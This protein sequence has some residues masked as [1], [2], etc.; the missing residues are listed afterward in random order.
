MSGCPLEARERE[1]EVKGR[2]TL[3]CAMTMSRNAARFSFGI[4]GRMPTHDLPGSIDSCFLGCGSACIWI[5]S[6]TSGTK[7]VIALLTNVRYV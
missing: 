5:K 3:V 7:I 2:L 4:S 1:R 6:N